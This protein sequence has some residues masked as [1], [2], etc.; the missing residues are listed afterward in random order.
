MLNSQWS[1]L[2]AIMGVLLIHSVAGV[3][4]LCW[5]NSWCWDMDTE[6]KMMECLRACRM[7]LSNES[8]VYPGNGHM[9]PLSENIPKYIHWNKLGKSNSNGGSLGNKRKNLSSDSSADLFSASSETQESWDGDSESHQEPREKQESKRSYAMEHFRWGKPVGRK[10]RPIRV[11]PN[12]VAEESEESYPEEFRR[13]LSWE[14]EYP[15]LDSLEEK[16]SSEATKV[17]KEKQLRKIKNDNTA[18]KMHH[19][20]WNTPGLSKKKRYGGFMTSE[21][22]HTPLVTLFKN[23]IIKTA[24]KKGQ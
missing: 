21:H 23:A 3:P 20:R 1:S 14:M 19:F 2:W 5:D 6:V 18:Y 13:D 7:G 12:G 8:P 17:D 24:Y 9:Q 11:N 22:S 16:Q 4:S 10:R 15:E